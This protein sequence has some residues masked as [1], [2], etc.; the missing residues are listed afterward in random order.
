LGQFQFRK[1]TKFQLQISLNEKHG[2][3]VLPELTGIKNSTLANTEKAG[4]NCLVSAPHGRIVEVQGPHFPAKVD[5][6]KHRT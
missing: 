6:Y 5:S 3:C 4:F 1:Y 2:I